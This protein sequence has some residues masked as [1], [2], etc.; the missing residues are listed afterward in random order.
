MLRRDRHVVG[1]GHHLVDVVGGP[2]ELGEDEGRRLVELDHAPQREL[3]VGCG[4]RVAGVEGLAGA[5]V[6]DDGVAVV[7]D[8]P[9]LGDPADQLHRARLVLGDAVVDVGD[10]LA[11]DQLEGLGRIERDDVVDVHRDDQ[12]RG[13]CLGLDCGLRA[14]AATSASAPATLS[15]VSPSGVCDSVAPPGPVNGRSHKSSRRARVLRRRRPRM[16]RARRQVRR[17]TAPGPGRRRR[18]GCSRRL[19]V[20]HH[21]RDRPAVLV[22]LPH[23]VERERRHQVAVAAAGAQPGR[24]RHRRAARLRW[25]RSPARPCG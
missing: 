15:F 11:A 1:R 5:D 4:Q 7:G 17:S 10:H 8:V 20:L 12:R 25:P 13:R 23:L 2:A 18:C 9:A 22:V 24:C 19:G 21:H 14:I 3:D 16:R 6:E